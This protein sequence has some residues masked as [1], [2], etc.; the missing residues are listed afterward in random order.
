LAAAGFTTSARADQWDKKTIMTVNEAIQ[1]PN[2]VLEAGTYV[3]KLADSPADRHIVQ[4]SL[5]MKSTCTTI[6]AIRTTGYSEGQDRIRFLGNH[7][8][9]QPRALARL[10]LSC[11]NFWSGVCLIRDD[12]L[13]DIREHSNV[14]VPIEPHR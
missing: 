14:T 2:K 6:L 12:V 10:V 4:I 3:F 13:A 8:P 1:V 5:R 9:A 7:L 11:D